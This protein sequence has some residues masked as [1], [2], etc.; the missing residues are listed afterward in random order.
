MN[1]KSKPYQPSSL[2]ETRNPMQKKVSSMYKDFK[3]VVCVV[4]FEVLQL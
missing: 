3:N 2:L 4:K 1:G